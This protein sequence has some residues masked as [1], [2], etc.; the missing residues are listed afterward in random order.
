M[1][2]QPLDTGQVVDAAARLA[3]RDGIDSVTLTAVAKELGVRQPALYRHV[4]SHQ[5]LLRS[6]GLRGRE[7][8]GAA[9]ADAAIGVSGDDAVAA[10]GHAWRSVVST[11]PGLYAATDRYPCAGD[12]ELEEAVERIVAIIAQA[13][14]GF[15]LDE[16][17][18]VHAARALRSAFHGFAH[19]E[20][21]DGYPQPHDIDDTF[22]G[23]IELLCAGIRSQAQQ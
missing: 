21:G 1:A 4:D 10:V 3:D 16:D 8:L 17:H 18:R 9:L 14:A 23:M 5:D 13:L 20:S 2:R 19:L 22:D 6:L 15:E 11:H 7:Y 12:P